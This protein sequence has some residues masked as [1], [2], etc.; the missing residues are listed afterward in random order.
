LAWQPTLGSFISRQQ[1]TWHSGKSVLTLRIHR[2]SL[3]TCDLVSLS[4]S[5]P[6][7]TNLA[8]NTPQLMHHLWKPFIHELSATN[9]VSNEGYKYKIGKGNH[10]WLKPMKKKLLILDVDT[11]LDTGD[12]SMMN[13]KGLKADKMS[14]RTAGMMSHY[15][16][17]MLRLLFFSKRICI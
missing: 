3:L 11:R 8:G 14:G 16:Y 2:P 1:A 17:G 12:D 13:P 15:L 7:P 6:L 10:R 9:F 4:L 5:S